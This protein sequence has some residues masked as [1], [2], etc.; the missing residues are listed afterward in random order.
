MTLTVDVGGARVA[1]GVEAVECQLEA[2]LA[3]LPSV[4]CAA[5]LGVPE[6]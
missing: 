4:D 2:L 1:L 3:R 6:T 5:N